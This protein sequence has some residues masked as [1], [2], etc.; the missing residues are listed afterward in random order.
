MLFT[1]FS[2]KKS[3]LFSL[4]FPITGGFFKVKPIL[5][6]L[7]SAMPD[8]LMLLLV[9][10]CPKGKVGGSMIKNINRYQSLKISFELAKV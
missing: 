2:E 9:H 1:L 4:I 10:T 7:V 8:L 6:R 3:A 5:V